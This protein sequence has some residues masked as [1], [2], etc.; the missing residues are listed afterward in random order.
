MSN[1][2][3]L[4][5]SQLRYPGT[6]CIW[7][8]L[9][10]LLFRPHNPSRFEWFEICLDWGVKRETSRKRN[11][12]DIHKLFKGISEEDNLLGHPDAVRVYFLCE[13]VS[14][15]FI[16]EWGV[17]DLLVKIWSK[18]N[19]ILISNLDMTDMQS[20]NEVL[21]CCRIAAWCGCQCNKSKVRILRH[22]PTNN[23]IV[24]VVPCSFMCFICTD[25]RPVWSGGIKFPHQ[26]REE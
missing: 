11:Q 17:A 8:K 6:G 25:L 9:D 3:P 16:N 22:H 24:C 1:E 14:P 18:I 19:A 4:I 12:A 26:L 2:T 23:L 5:T 20:I 13:F 21:N 7:M 10:R 15:N